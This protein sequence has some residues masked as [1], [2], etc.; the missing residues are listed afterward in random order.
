VIE[1]IRSHRDNAIS[2]TANDI[3]K[4]GKDARFAM[5]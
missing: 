5:S 4:T 1:Q 3:T 2:K